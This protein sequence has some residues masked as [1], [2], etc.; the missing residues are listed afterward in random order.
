MVSIPFPLN[1]SRKKISVQEEAN[2]TVTDL[3]I[4]ELKTLTKRILLGVVN[5]FGDLFGIASPFIMRYKVVM[6]HLFLLEEPLA[7]DEPIP[8][9]NSHDRIKL[10]MET[11]ESQCFSWRRSCDNWM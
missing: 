3:G 10:M 1:L 2:L 11:F 6:R 7:W 8:Q 9:N 4:L 5:E